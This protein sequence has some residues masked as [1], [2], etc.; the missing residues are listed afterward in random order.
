MKNMKKILFFSLL[1]LS[2]VVVNA[3][4]SVSA[5]LHHDG[6]FKI[7]FS[8][9][10]LEEALAEAQLGDVINLSAG[11]FNAPT[12]KVPV[13]I[14]G[15]GIGS[16][17]GNGSYSPYKTQILNSF[18]INIPEDEENYTLSME[19]IICENIIYITSLVDGMFSKMVFNGDVA[20]YSS[21]PVINNL[22][23]FHCVFNGS[24]NLKGTA[25]FQNSV[26]NKGIRMTSFS[27]G[28][29][30][31][32]NNCIFSGISSTY[33]LDSSYIT[34]TNCIFDIS[35]YPSESFRNSPC[36]N[37]L[38]I[39]G[40]ENSFGNTNTQVERNNRVLPADSQAFVDNSFFKLTDTAA[41]YLGIDG[42]QVGIYGGA[43]PFSAKTSY[44]QLK[45]F[46][47]ASESTSDGKLM[48]EFEIDVE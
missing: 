31:D 22:T 2:Y 28:T 24:I 46:S 5:T 8:S 33:K 7:F 10:A 17:E 20:N 21:N 38:C 45:S 30:L 32:M 48:I 11:S 27:S 9:S 36:Y 29:T 41:S 14:R 44:P 42:T 16:L 12:I 43:Y 47:V 39:G 34:Y 1:L 19:G 4:G 25:Q 23:F 13:T 40:D 26:F 35:G 6:E 15:A 37:C 3:Q 18:Y